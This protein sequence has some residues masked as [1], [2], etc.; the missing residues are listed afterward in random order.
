M[1]EAEL[2]KQSNIN[3][4]FMHGLIY[5]IHYRFIDKT[6]FMHNEEFHISNPTQVNNIND[7]VNRIKHSQFFFHIYYDRLIQDSYCIMN[8][9]ATNRSLLESR[10]VKIYNLKLKIFEEKMKQLLKINLF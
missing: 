9:T 8:I 6:H 2:I 1:N 7:L 4:L 3:L 5:G 10:S